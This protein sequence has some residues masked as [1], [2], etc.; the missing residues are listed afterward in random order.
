MLQAN[1][2]PNYYKYDDH[3]TFF[4]SFFLLQGGMRPLHIP[5]LRLASWAGPM[6]SLMGGTSAV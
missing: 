4:D 6:H 2:N 3:N 5:V 1:Q